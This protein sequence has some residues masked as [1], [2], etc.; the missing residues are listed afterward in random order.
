MSHTQNDSGNTTAENDVASTSNAIGQTTDVVGMAHCSARDETAGKLMID[1]WRSCKVYGDDWRISHAQGLKRAPRIPNP[2]LDSIHRLDVDFNRAVSTLGVTKSH[3]RNALTK[4]GS[5]VTGKAIPSRSLRAS[6]K[7]VSKESVEP[8]VGGEAKS[9][10]KGRGEEAKLRVHLAVL[11]YFEEHGAF[12]VRSFL[13][14]KHQIAN[15]TAKKYWPSLE[16]LGIKPSVSNVAVAECEEPL[17][18]AEVKGLDLVETI[19]SL[20][21]GDELVDGTYDN[22]DGVLCDAVRTD[23]KGKRPQVHAWRKHQKAVA[24]I[25]RLAEQLQPRQHVSYPPAM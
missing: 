4:R 20:V 17:Q 3:L 19:S 23:G 21:F 18:S 7:S 12:P 2:I 1:L 6:V 10:R 9:L 15:A 24:D 13:C 16:D 22:G 11:E 8:H 5:A 25:I 14:T